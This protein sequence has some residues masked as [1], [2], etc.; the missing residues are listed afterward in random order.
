M[1]DLSDLGMSTRVYCDDARINAKLGLA[2]SSGLSESD[3]ITTYKHFPGAGDGS[4]YP[5]S[6]DLT[7]DELRESGQ[8]DADAIVCAYL[9]AG[10]NVDFVY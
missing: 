4:D 8:I 7:M 3:I 1:Q 2:F 6:I 9:A 5:T 10:M